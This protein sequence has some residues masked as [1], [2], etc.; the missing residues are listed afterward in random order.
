MRLITDTENLF[1]QKKMKL[2]E[3]NLELNK[4]TCLLT[5]FNSS[6]QIDEEE[7]EETLAN[8]SHEKKAKKERILSMEILTSSYLTKSTIIKLTSQGY[9]QGARKIR[10]GITYFG[11]EDPDKCDP[12]NVSVI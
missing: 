8:L 4:D 10:D 5:N 12:N 1:E 11:F 6:E 2:E 9:A 3:I 7:Q